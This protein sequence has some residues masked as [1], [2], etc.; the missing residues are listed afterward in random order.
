MSLN[1]KSEEAHRLAKELA[2]RRS[3]SLTEAV[4]TALRQSLRAGG[5]QPSPFQALLAEVQDVQALVAALPDL[6][7]READAVLGYDERGLP[8]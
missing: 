8:T 3:S 2:S 5:E 4:T 7:P 1:I 6:D